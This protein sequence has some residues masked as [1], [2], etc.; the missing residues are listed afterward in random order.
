MNHRF[1]ASLISLLIAIEMTAAFGTEL[2]DV[3]AHPE[4][5]E[6]RDV[7]LVGIARVPGYFYLFADIESAAKTDLS[8]ALLIRQNSFAGKEYREADR[9]WVRVTGL[10]SSESRRG[11]DFGT[12]VLLDRVEFRRDRPPPPI[13]DATVLGVF[14]NAT[15]RSLAIEII[16][17]S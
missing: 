1:Q 13:K 9:Q 14:Q 11:W 10:M 17:P 16:S 7:D 5:Y 12:G 3:L 8:K 2:R 4:K 6:Q 15:N